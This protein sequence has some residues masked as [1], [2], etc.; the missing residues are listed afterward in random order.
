MLSNINI[1]LPLLTSTL[2]DHVVDRARTETSVT[3]ELLVTLTQTGLT[4]SLNHV[5]RIIGHTI[6]CAEPF[7]L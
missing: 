1:I 2:D 4:T 5:I 6:Y 7:A 3:V